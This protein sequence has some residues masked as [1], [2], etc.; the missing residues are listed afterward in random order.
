[1]KFQRVRKK[2]RKASRFIVRVG[3][4]EPIVF[5]DKDDVF[6]FESERHYKPYK[7]RFEDLVRY[8]ELKLLSRDYKGKT[9]KPKAPKEESKPKESTP[10]ANTSD[11]K[12]LSDYKVAE[13][14][15][16]AKSKGIEFPNNAKKADLVALLS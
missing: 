2:D 12:T 16:M 13:L 11:E 14:K 10:E 9:K 6:Q 15:E 7:K 4:Q 3:S 1:M 5:T 8:N